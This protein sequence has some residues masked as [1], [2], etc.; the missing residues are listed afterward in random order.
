MITHLQN[1]TPRLLLTRLSIR[2]LAQERLQD[3]A[4][5]DLLHR[6]GRVV[7]DA[8]DNGRRGLQARRGRRIRNVD[9]RREG[10]VSIRVPLRILRQDGVDLRSIAVHHIDPARA[11][12]LAQNID[13]GAGSSAAADNQRRLT[14]EQLADRIPRRG[15]RVLQQRL[16]DPD[17]VGVRAHVGRRPRGRVA[18]QEDGVAGA[19]LLCVLGEVVQM[20]H[21]VDLPGHGDG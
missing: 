15:R 3:L 2:L 4:R 7:R 5:P 14:A 12:P 20:R 18:A 1:H 11:E 10:A 17:A 8:R 6:L 9:Q 21:D 13:G 19:G 16:P